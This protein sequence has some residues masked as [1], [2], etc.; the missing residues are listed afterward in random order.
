MAA[1][2]SITK[3]G[4][5]PAQAGGDGYAFAFGTAVPTASYDTSGSVMDM[6]DIFAKTCVKVVF[7]VANA[8]FR[9][10][11]QPTASTYAT[12]TGVVFIDDNAGTEASST[13]NVATTVTSCS[14]I[15]WGTDA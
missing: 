15:A 1:F 11:F 4:K 10:D 12:A 9:F 8:D 2:T 6:S 13:D 3:V 5:N 7:T 14:W